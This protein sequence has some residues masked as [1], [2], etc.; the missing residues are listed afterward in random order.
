MA[1][2]T[3][4]WSVLCAVAGALW[5]VGCGHGVA[6]TGQADDEARL[7]SVPG[8]RLGVCATLKFL[9]CSMRRASRHHA[10]TLQHDTMQP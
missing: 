7:N 8:G 2:R 9:C 6:V 4:V 1:V 5:A 3:V 10:P